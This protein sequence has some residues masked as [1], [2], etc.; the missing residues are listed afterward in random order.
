M[1]DEDANGWAPLR[2]LVVYIAFGL[3]LFVLVVG[4]IV[5]LTDHKELSWGAYLQNLTIITAALLLSIGHVRI[6]L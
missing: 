2:P 4:G 1:S 3:A 6:R 5:T